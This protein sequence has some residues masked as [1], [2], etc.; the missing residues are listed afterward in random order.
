LRSVFLYSAIL[1]SAC[2]AGSNNNPATEAASEIT[3]THLKL[4]EADNTPVNWAQYKGK[5]VF[6]NFWATWCKPCLREMPSIQKAMKILKNDNVIFLFA[7]D[8]EADL[9]EEFKNKHD[10]QF[11]YVRVENLEELNIMALPAT[12]IFNPE[13]ELAFSDMGFRKWD[14]KKNIDLVL[15]ITKSK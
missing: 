3:I 15:N 2:N 8:E 14:D 5:T 6:I 9:I 12:F 10:Y 4:S 1:F 11:N 13:G 7:S